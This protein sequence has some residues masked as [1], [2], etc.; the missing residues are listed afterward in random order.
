MEQTPSYIVQIGNID[1]DS[2]MYSGTGFIVGHYLITA[3]HVVLNADFFMACAFIN[4]KWFNIRF[5]GTKNRFLSIDGDEN[6][7]DVAIIDLF[8][9]NNYTNYNKDPKDFVVNSPLKM[10]EKKALIGDKVQNMYYLPESDDIIFHH[11]TDNE[12]VDSPFK[13]LQTH[14]AYPSRKNTFF[15][16]HSGKITNGASGSPVIVNNEVIGIVIAGIRKD[17]IERELLP[18]EFLN[19]CECF[20]LSHIR[21]YLPDL[22][23]DEKND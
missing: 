23:T 9:V 12:I 4:N 5:A 13:I 16:K 17:L 6:H 22:F 18:S 11:E 7:Q 2:G 15:L 20:G 3:A 10:S 21:D 8:D 1:G 14:N 19:Y